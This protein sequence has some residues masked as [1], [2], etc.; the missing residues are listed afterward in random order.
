MVDG[1]LVDGKSDLPDGV[2]LK[3]L[4]RTFYHDE[5]GMYVTAVWRLKEA[6]HDFEWAKKNPEH[7][8]YIK[9]DDKNEVMF[10]D[11]HSCM[12]MLE[13]ICTHRKRVSNRSLGELHL[14]VCKE[15]IDGE[16]WDGDFAFP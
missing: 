15:I 5:R 3:Y 13:Q 10:K 4:V 12:Y 8:H 9:D 11:R 2:T 6:E 16:Y 7:H 1:K 14:Q